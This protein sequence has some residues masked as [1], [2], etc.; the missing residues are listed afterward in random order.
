MTNAKTLQEYLTASEINEMYPMI[1]Y[2]SQKLRQS[3]YLQI[4]K[5]EQKNGKEA[6]VKKGT[7]TMFNAKFAQDILNI[8]IL[9]FK[10]NK[11]V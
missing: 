8:I 10:I 11:E 1:P 2:A 9:N 3:P 7:I 6:L 5:W 4:K